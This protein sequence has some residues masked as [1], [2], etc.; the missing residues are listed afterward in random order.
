MRKVNFKNSQICHQNYTFV[1]EK[2]SKYTSIDL[3]K[4]FTYLDFGDSYHPSR[5]QKCPPTVVISLIITYVRILVVPGSLWENKSRL[6]FLL[7]YW[8]CLVFPI[9][10]WALRAKVRSAFKQVSQALVWRDG[11]WCLEVS[12]VYPLLTCK[13]ISMD[14]SFPPVFSHGVHM[15]FLWSGHSP[16]PS[17]TSGDT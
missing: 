6:P 7:L 14:R 11:R 15:T 12:E 1:L 9:R 3:I 16:H 10:V 2:H 13:A 4:W 8:G 17:F 5:W